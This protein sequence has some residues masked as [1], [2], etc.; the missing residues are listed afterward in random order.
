MASAHAHAASSWLINKELP[1]DGH[2]HGRR[3][4]HRPLLT[5][6]GGRDI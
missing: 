5:M 2:L 1:R 4:T 3:L 6:H